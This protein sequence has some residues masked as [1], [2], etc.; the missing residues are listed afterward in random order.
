MKVKVPDGF[1]NPSSNVFQISLYLMIYA[2]SWQIT[3][4]ARDTH[5]LRAHCFLYVT[6]EQLHVW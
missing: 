1:S 3:C 4:A 5:G 6:Y 2:Q